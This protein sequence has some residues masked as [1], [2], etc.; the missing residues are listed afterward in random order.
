MTRRHPPNSDTGGNER[1]L[2][3]HAKCF[4]FRST[5]IPNARAYTHANRSQSKDGVGRRTMLCSA[6]ARCLS[7]CSF[8]CESRIRRD[9]RFGERRH[10]RRHRQAPSS[11]TRA[12]MHAQTTS[13]ENAGWHCGA[14]AQVEK[15]TS[16]MRSGRCYC[17]RCR[18]AVLLLVLL[19]FMLLLH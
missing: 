7:V 18:A 16:R 19:W 4:S 8:V 5:D 10:H 13:R 1:V 3:P 15:R 6:V 12:H 17:H 2:C 9:V 14:C 11:R